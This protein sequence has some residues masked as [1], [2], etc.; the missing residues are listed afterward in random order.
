MTQ[1]AVEWLENQIKTSKYSYKLIA[2]INS[3][4]TVVQSDIFE[5]AKEMEKKQIMNSWVRGVISENNAT[6]E[7]HYN[8]TFKKD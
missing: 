7:Q 2:D 4:G 3:R 5:Q 1:T 6:A 8:E